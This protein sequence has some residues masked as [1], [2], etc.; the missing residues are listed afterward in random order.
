[1]STTTTPA[2][3]SQ[4]SGSYVERAIDV[5]LTLGTGTFGQTGFNT[6]KLSG[7]RVVANITKV[8]SPSFDTANIRV[9]GVP[10]SVMNQ[11]TTL[12]VY[13]TTTRPNNTIAVAAGDSVNGMA[14]IYQGQLK[15]AWQN[16]DG[17]PETFLSLQG[18]GAELMAMQPIAPTSV[19]GT[20]DVA[21]LIQGLAIQGGWGFENNGVTT[22]LPSSYFPGTAMDQIHAIARAANI[23]VYFDTGTPGPGTPAPTPGTGTVAIWPKTG[24]RI[25]QIPL[26]SAATGLIGYPRYF[27][28]GM[29]FRCIFNRNISL[30]GRITM[31]SIIGGD[32]VPANATLQQQLQAGPNGEWYVVGQLTHD[33]SSQVPGGPWFTDVNCSRLLV[34]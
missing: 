3:T 30:Y 12:G 33:L 17:S 14:L 28:Q 21:S 27:D 9:Y 4:Q 8:G 18:I 13:Y 25:K 34:P 10:P 31:Q 19:A 15:N 7:L 5:T 26:I 20:A 6:V 23:E 32:P 16:L 24:T 1:M 29:G 2:S 22:K 11:V